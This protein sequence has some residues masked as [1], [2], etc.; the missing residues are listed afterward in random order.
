MKGFLAVGTGRPRILPSMWASPGQR[1]QVPACEQEE[2]TV[3]SFTL[4]ERT[5]CI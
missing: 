2:H 4:M 1:V 5:S 3:K